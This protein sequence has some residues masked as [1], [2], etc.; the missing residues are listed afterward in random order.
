M[1]RSSASRPRIPGILAGW[2][3]RLLCLL[4]ASAAVSACGDDDPLGPDPALAE[5]VGDWEARALE[6][7][8]EANPSEVADLI[9]AG[10]T[11]TLNVQPSGQYTATLVFFGQPL[12]EIGQVTVDGSRITLDPSTPADQPSTTGT[13]QVQG[14]LFTLDGDTEFDFNGDG[15][16]EAARAHFELLRQ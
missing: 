5:L 7:T 9:E 12:T 14:D 10:A 15:T 2:L 4:V 13:Y 1:T 16:A 11:F 6:I 3:P 8:N